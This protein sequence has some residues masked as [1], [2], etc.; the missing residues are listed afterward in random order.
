MGKK[1]FFFSNFASKVWNEENTQG[2][3]QYKTSFTVTSDH[4]LDVGNPSYALTHDRDSK[5]S[6][7]SKRIFLIHCTSKTYSLRMETWLSMIF[8]RSVT[9]VIA[10][11]V[12]SIEKVFN[13]YVNLRNRPVFI[14]WNKNSMQHNIFLG[15]LWGI[16]IRARLSLAIINVLPIAHCI[17]WSFLQSMRRISSI[18]N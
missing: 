4:H 12:K 15:C 11:R 10:D 3:S 14:R 8:T 9:T 2:I 17:H 16:S 1:Y 7:Y 13:K 18:A 6:N 5:R